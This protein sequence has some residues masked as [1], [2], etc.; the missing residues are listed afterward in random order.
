MF[1]IYLAILLLIAL[2]VAVYFQSDPGQRFWWEYCQYHHSCTLTVNWISLS[3]STVQFCLWMHTSSFC[4]SITTTKTPSSMWLKL[5]DK[6]CSGLPLKRLHVNLKAIAHEKNTISDQVLRQDY[7]SFWFK[8][9]LYFKKT[10]QE[11]RQSIR[12]KLAGAYL[13]WPWSSLNHCSTDRKREHFLSPKPDGMRVFILTFV[14]R[15]KQ[16][17]MLLLLTIIPSLFSH[18]SGTV[19]LKS[20]DRWNQPRVSEHCIM[21]L[22]AFVPRV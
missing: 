1:K 17:Q 8:F 12:S 6:F 10:G 14:P 20:F 4:A 5:D 9:W 7:N 13:R 3:F 18:C 2:K 16:I 15:A 21:G 22:I 19:L 11:E